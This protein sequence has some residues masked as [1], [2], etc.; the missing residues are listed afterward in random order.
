MAVGH[1]PGSPNYRSSVKY[2]STSQTAEP[3]QGGRAAELPVG[4]GGRVNQ[5]MISW[6][7]PEKCFVNVSAWISIK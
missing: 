5:K 1:W 7:E 3:L 6:T 4:A 2:L